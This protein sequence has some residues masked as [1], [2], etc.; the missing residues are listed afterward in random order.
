MVALTWFAVPLPTMSDLH[1]VGWQR[2]L[3]AKDS[4]AA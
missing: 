3:P 2:R 4:A 1:H